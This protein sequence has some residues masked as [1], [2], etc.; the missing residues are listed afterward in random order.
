VTAQSTP[1]AG[2][3]LFGELA[4]VTTEGA[5]VGRGAVAIGTVN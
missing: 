4:V 3:E 5:V 2:R 1:G